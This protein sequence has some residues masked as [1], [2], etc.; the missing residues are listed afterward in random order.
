MTF[1]MVASL[2]PLPATRARG[3]TLPAATTLLL[4]A[5]SARVAALAQEDAGALDEL[6]LAPNLERALA[7]HLVRRY[8]R[9]FPLIQLRSP[10]R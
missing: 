7:L 1:R 9:F 2:R 6:P 3:S 5:D 8:S 10:D 4:Y